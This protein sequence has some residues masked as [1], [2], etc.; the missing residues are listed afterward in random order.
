MNPKSD[1]YFPQPESNGG[2]RFLKDADEI[3]DLTS[4]N[5]GKLDDVIESYKFF[6]LLLHDMVT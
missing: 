3:T 2:W 5:L 6:L 4:M 1:N